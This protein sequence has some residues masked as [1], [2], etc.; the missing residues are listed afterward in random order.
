MNVNV[1]NQAD[2]RPKEDVQRP[3]NLQG[4]L[5]WVEDLFDADTERGWN[6]NSLSQIA[7]STSSSFQNHII[8]EIE[9]GA[10]DWNIIWG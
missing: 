3:L 5:P 7:P 2:C 8:L 1:W 6:P 10:E 4:G 9:E